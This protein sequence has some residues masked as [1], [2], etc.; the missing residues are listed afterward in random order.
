MSRKN[1]SSSVSISCIFIYSWFIW[2]CILY[3]VTFLIDKDTVSSVFVALSS[4]CFR[5]SP[6]SDGEN[7]LWRLREGWLC[8]LMTLYLTQASPSATQTWEQHSHTWVCC[9]KVCVQSNKTDRHNRNNNY[10]EFFNSFCH[11]SGSARY[12]LKYLEVTNINF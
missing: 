6:V 7:S 1:V 10:F 12:I 11:C 8:M 2:L 4:A 5:N 3:I 9:T